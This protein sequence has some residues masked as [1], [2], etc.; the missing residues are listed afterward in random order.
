MY[1]LDRVESALNDPRKTTRGN[2]IAAIAVGA[3]C[4]ACMHTTATTTKN[5]EQLKRHIFYAHISFSQMSSIPAKLQLRRTNQKKNVGIFMP[6]VF[7]VVFFQLSV[8]SQQHDN[9]CT[10]I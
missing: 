4:N 8:H 10:R 9:L 6:V 3:A 5:S 1:K 2:A 7:S